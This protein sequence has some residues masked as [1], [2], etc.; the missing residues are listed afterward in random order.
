MDFRHTICRILH[1]EH[2]ATIEML[3]GLEDLLARGRRGVPDLEAVHSRKVL[4]D[5]AQM[6]E[7]ELTRHFA[8][9][10]QQLFTRLSEAGDGA[11]GE[12]LTE[13]HHTMLPVA[14]RLSDMASQALERGMEEMQWE[15]FRSLGAELIE[16]MQAH[17]QKEEMALLP[18][19]E[20]TLEP[21]DDLA[22]AEAYGGQA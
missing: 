13:E 14:Q 21:E 7:Q 6:T 4:A 8:F 3:D 17:I 9:E 11:I 1:D 2:H 12:H 18:M 10:E 5:L 20:E 16:R 19:L 15:E 22:L